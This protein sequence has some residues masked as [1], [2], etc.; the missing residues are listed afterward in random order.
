MYLPKKPRPKKTS[1]TR[2]RTGCYT[3][4]SRRKKCDEAKPVCQNCLYSGVPCEVYNGPRLFFLDTTEAVAKR[5]ERIESKRW[6]AIHQR[7]AATGGKERQSRARNHQ[8]RSASSHTPSVGTEV[9][10][11]ESQSLL[12]LAGA[13]WDS[14]SDLLADVVPFSPGVRSS[15]AHRQSRGTD[16]DNVNAHVYDIDVRVW[17]DA[18]SLPGTYS[19]GQAREEHQYLSHFHSQL[20]AS[21]FTPSLV[22]AARSISV[23]PGLRDALLA[24]AASDLANN[25]GFLNRHRD[26]HTSPLLDRGHYSRAVGYYAKAIRTLA[27]ASFTSVIDQAD[28][29]AA[30]LF[31]AVFELATGSPRGYIMHL[32]GANTLALDHHSIISQSTHGKSILSAWSR[33]RASQEQ[34]WLPFR[35]LEEER[36]SVRSRTSYS[37]ALAYCTAPSDEIRIIFAHA[38]AIR[39]RIIMQS[40][41]PNEVATA[42]WYKHNFGKSYTVD[43][44][45]TDRASVLDND[46]LLHLLRREKLKLA[47]WHSRLDRTELP[48]DLFTA[49]PTDLKS[50]DLLSDPSH[51]PITF[52]SLRS[53]CQ[54]ICYALTQL[55]CD[56]DSLDSGQ[57]GSDRGSERI[58]LEGTPSH[59]AHVI[60]RTLWGLDLRPCHT[61]IFDLSFETITIYL[62]ETYPR[63]WLTEHLLQKL[64]PHLEQKAASA[65][66]K[67]SIA[68]ARDVVRL[69]DDELGK[70]TPLLVIPFISID[71][72]LTELW[73]AQDRR[74]AAVHGMSPDGPFSTYM[75]MP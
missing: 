25:Y 73:G 59:W 18:V 36:L 15:D 23:V 43:L 45:L 34:Y 33:L 6:A 9:T 61:T 51:R 11:P 42:Q 13:G 17:N 63:K 27:D 44:Q 56:E 57:D 52:L 40:I 10:P 37:L 72:E 55:V 28:W 21:S 20:C 67:Y 29:L 39:H 54:Y 47:K 30:I 58:G 46:H 60:L 24:L 2:S 38:G 22:Q 4:R 68:L 1:I 64:L 71:Q 53:A 69:Y 12:S 62:V 16:A 32:E 65:S 31:C 5:A 7:E 19:D 26:D 14:P 48:I 50:Y 41:M 70:R 35:P 49:L 74:Q 8:T 75:D 3:C 66:M